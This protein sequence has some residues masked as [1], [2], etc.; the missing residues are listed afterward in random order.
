MSVPD[1]TVEGNTTGLNGVRYGIA[2]EGGMDGAYAF[3]Q[4][5]NG[6]LVSSPFTVPPETQT[7]R[8][9]WHTPYGFYNTVTILD[10]AGQ[11]VLG[12]LVNN[13]GSNGQWQAAFANISAFQGQTVRLRF[14]LGG[15]GYLHVDNVVLTPAP[16]AA[17]TVVETNLPE[18]TSSTADSVALQVYGGPRIVQNFGDYLTSIT[19]TPTLTPYVTVTPTVTPS[20]TG[21][22]PYTGRVLLQG[23]SNSIGTQISTG[24]HDVTFFAADGTFT[25]YLP[26]G[27]QTLTAR[28]SLYLSRALPL[29][30]PPHKPPQPFT[31]PP[32][33]LLGGDTDDNGVINI[34]DL[35]RVGANYGAKPLADTR[36][37]INADGQVNLLDL[38]MVGANYGQEGPLPWPT[39]TA[40]PLLDIGSAKRALP[41]AVVLHTPDRVAPGEPFYVRV[42]L[43]RG[44]GVAGA[45]VNLR[46]DP[47]DLA[48]VEGAV[49]GQACPVASGLAPAALAFPDGFIVPIASWPERG[50]LRY[51]LVQR[52]EAATAD[53]TL[54]CVRFQSRVEGRPAVALDKATLIT[55]EGDLMDF[56]PPP[57]GTPGDTR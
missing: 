19:P 12:T 15:Y 47:T 3:L 8:W 50:I 14:A 4:E 49:T 30:A 9:W 25:I 16:T 20:P 53:G 6:A 52:G 37:D 10:A 31:L 34:L 35:I 33:T 5:L 29:V 48:L 17:Y 42:Q 26:P 46:F 36:A 23:R 45:E 41:P 39:L 32:T 38:L 13:G 22:I 51:A 7:L 11:T 2:S 28:H 40:T 18:W 27:P 54:L 1:W 56:F 44:A 43:A 24:F 57:I 55:R 21:G